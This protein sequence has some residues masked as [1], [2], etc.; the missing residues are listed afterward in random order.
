VSP[1]ISITRPLALIAAL[2]LGACS[3]QSG[4]S[5]VKP[6]AKAP[7][8]PGQG[9]DK[10]RL[11]AGIDEKFGGVGT[12]V[13][14]ADT[15]SGQELYRYNSH[16][17][18][19]NPLPPCSTFK[20][21]NSLIALDAGVVTPQTVFKWDRTPQRVRAWEQDADMRTAFS[22]S[23]V[24]WYQ[25]VAQN[26]GQA[27]YQERLKAFDYG[28]KAPEGP[29]TTFWIGPAAGGRLGISTRQQTEFLRRLYTGR[30]P[31]KPESS[32]FVQSIMVNEVRDGFTMSGKTGSC[33]TLA[34]SSRWVGWWVGR[35]KGPSSD[36][37]F[38]ASVET[39]SGNALPG[40]EVE[41][42]VKSVFA[43]AGLWPSA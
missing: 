24:W 35:L 3:P 31:V 19:M 21:P 33:P 29:L 13:I 27:A 30:L 16:G 26:V 14:V 5:P 6:P 38:A 37:V 36:Y 28:N 15:R 9:F 25:R 41:A 39:E 1:R 23:I 17:V 34:D 12:C 22:K 43:D 18:C 40:L 4:Q 2:A 7:A 20:I 32:A 8:A 42:R 10:A 11:E